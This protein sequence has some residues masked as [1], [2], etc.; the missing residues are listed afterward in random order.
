MG[1]KMKNHEEYVVLVDEN[2]KEIG[3]EKK[4]IVHTSKTPLHRA[5]SLFLFND[6]NELLLQQRSN[7]KTAWPLVWSN[8][9][10]GHPLPGESYKNAVLRRTCYEL[11]IKLYSLKKLSD[12]MYCF[13]KDGIMENEICPVFVG[14]YDDMIRPNP[15]EV[16][17]VKWISWKDWLEETMKNPEDYSPWCVEETKILAYKNNT[18]LYS[19]HFDNDIFID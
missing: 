10:C 4:A 15:L 17:S 19:N 3:I 2:D 18:N 9:C 5:F 16:A 8:S 6:K 13:T 11:G 7:E 14:F 1:N 12:Y